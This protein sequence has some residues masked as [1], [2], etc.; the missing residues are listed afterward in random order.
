MKSFYIAARARHRIK[1]VTELQ[2]FLSD[3]GLE[4]VFNW[5]ELD[6]SDIK[7]PY[8]DN[9]QSSADI[10]D[11]M[12]QAS[13]SADVFIL[14][15]DTG[16]EGALMEY[17]V[18]RYSAIENQDKLVLVVQMGGQDSIFLHRKNVIHFKSI[19]QLKEWIIE[20]L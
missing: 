12:L 6:A 15:H 13:F 16:L 2:D 17:G 3:R 18:A 14:L 11:R 4:N 10:G 8:A 7:K 5:S 19:E 9:L 1:E 20:N